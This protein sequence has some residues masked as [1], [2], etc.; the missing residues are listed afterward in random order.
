MRADDFIGYVVPCECNGRSDSC[1]RETGK[2]LLCQKNT[3][4]QNCE[5]C[6]EGYYGDPSSEQGC[7]ACPC[8]ETR[9]NFA[10]GCQV[11]DHQVNCIC[12]EGMFSKEREYYFKDY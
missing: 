2:C 7:Q 4:G 6:A 11:Y 12:K 10:K 8:P 9:K 1:D 3:G 5:L